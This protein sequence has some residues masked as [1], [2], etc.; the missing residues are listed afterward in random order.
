[1][2]LQSHQCDDE[3][4]NGRRNLNPFLVYF[5]APHLCSYL[6]DDHDCLFGDFRPIRISITRAAVSS[7]IGQ[8]AAIGL[9]GFV[10]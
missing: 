3:L 7:Q 2:A 5:N 8:S 1:V 4:R 9:L 10:F 6:L